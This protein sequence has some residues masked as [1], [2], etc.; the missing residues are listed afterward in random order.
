M[1]KVYYISDEEDLRFLPELQEKD[2]IV[3][4]QNRGFVIYRGYIVSRKDV[5]SYRNMIG[6]PIPKEMRDRSWTTNIKIAKQFA[7]EYKS[8]NPNT[9]VIPV[10][11]KAKSNKL[12]IGWKYE[13]EV[14]IV[15]GAK[16][17]LVDI[18]EFE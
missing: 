16:T 6:K 3:A 12:E 10:I 18:I 8:G 4:P 14:Y 7:E 9:D 1:G 15:N 13:A 2:V 5:K 11:F 17:K